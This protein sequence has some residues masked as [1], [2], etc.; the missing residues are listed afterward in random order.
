M[1]SG[2]RV[3]LVDNNDHV[4]RFSID[5]LQGR[6][7]R[8][9]PE[10]ARKRVRY[11]LVVLACM[12]RKPLYIEHIDC[13]YITFDRKGRLDS[14]QIQQAMKCAAMCITEIGSKQESGKVIDAST[15][16]AKRRYSHEHS[17]RPTPKI[18]KE[19][20]GKLFESK[21]LGRRS[22]TIHK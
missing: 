16:F 14:S 12:N 18:I 4:L 10:F 9:H 8:A 21:T 15:H 11:A 22:L 2:I 7:R 1:G 13:G 17:W 5:A 6:S 19:L 20:K 3:F